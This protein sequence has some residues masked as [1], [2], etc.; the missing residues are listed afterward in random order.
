MAKS[1]Q[2][3]VFRKRVPQKNARLLSLYFSGVMKME[4]RLTPVKA[5][6]AKCLDC[7]CGQMKEV[8]ECRILRCSL[9]PY[10]MGKR[11]QV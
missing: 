9:Y 7:C 6:R 11:P 10:R 5:I 1:M 4:K 2:V 3:K 8:K